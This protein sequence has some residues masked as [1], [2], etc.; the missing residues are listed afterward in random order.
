[1][2]CIVTTIKTEKLC[3]SPCAKS[4]SHVQLFAT[5]GTVAPGSSV[6]GD[7]LGK[8]TGVGCHTLLQGNLPNPGIEPR[9]PTFPDRFFTI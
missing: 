4:L 8:N 1:M 5:P 7:S 9:S 6:H 3:F 2:Y